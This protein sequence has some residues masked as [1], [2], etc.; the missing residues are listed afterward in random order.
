M[1]DLQAVTEKM[2]VAMFK[3]GEEFDDQEALIPN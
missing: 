1:F 2:K 3:N